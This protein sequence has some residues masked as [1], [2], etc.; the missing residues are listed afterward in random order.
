MEGRGR[1][2]VVTYVWLVVGGWSEMGKVVSRRRAKKVLA[3]QSMRP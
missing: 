2:G 1:E 3:R